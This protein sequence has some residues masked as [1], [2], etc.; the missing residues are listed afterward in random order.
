MSPSLSGLYLA[1]AGFFILE[2]AVKFLSGGR[3]VVMIYHM[4]IKKSDYQS[5]PLDAGKDW[6][7]DTAVSF[8]SS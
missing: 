4:P 6:F 7:L 2:V 3:E 1:L 8:G 5:M